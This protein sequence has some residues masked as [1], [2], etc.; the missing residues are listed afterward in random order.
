MGLVSVATVFRSGAFD[1]VCRVRVC[2]L[3]AKMVLGRTGVEAD[4]G[5]E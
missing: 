2:E 3:D 1:C 4:C 5:H